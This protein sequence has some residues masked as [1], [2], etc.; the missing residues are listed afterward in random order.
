MFTDKHFPPTFLSK[1]P[2]LRDMVK[3]QTDYDRRITP[4]STKFQ[5]EINNSNEKQTSTF[6]RSATQ[7][8]VQE[9]GLSSS[10]CTPSS[11]NIGSITK[12]GTHGLPLYPT[13]LRIGEERA[14]RASQRR[15][16]RNTPTKQIDTNIVG[17]CNTPNIYMKSIGS[18]HNFIQE[19]DT[20]PPIIFPQLSYGRVTP[21]RNLFPNPDDSNGYTNVA[22]HR[23]SAFYRYQC[24]F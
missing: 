9:R 14:I 13:D 3:D 6:H 12:A 7:S 22:L 15:S 5:K 11:S 1:N 10:S 19:Q 8:S 17:R 18:D 16:M 23:P 20:K 2:S 4:I 21:S 24:Y